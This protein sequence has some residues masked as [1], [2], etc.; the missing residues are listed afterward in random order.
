MEP[1]QRGLLCCS[2]NLSSFNSDTNQVLSEELDPVMTLIAVV[3]VTVAD[4]G[5]SL[6]EGPTTPFAPLQ[7][8]EDWVVMLLSVA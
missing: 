7:A 1:T 8:G 4:S 6:F 2:C 3:N 5:N